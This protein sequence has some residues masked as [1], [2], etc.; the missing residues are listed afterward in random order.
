VSDARTNT[1]TP[2]PPADPKAVQTE[3]TAA[4][5]AKIDRDLAFL[6]HCF[7]EMLED[8]GEKE[9]ARHVAEGTW[10]GQ[11]VPPVEPTSRYPERIGQVYSIAFQLLN[12]VEENAAA[13][14]RR[15]RE[16]ALGL[17]GEPGLWGRYLRELKAAGMKGPDIAD[18]LPAIRVEPVLTAHPTEAKR[19]TVLEQHRAIYALMERMDANN[20]SPAGR[21]ALKDEVKAALERLWRTGEILVSKPEVADERENLMYYLVE[22]FPEV[23]RGVDAR[24]RQAWADA[25]LDP[26][27]VASHQ[28]M[29]KLRFGFW[30]GGD[31]DGHPMVTP[32]VTRQTLRALR[33]GAI[34]VLRRQLDRL[35][36]QL[37]LSVHGQR[38][39]PELTGL[40]E[41]LAEQHPSMARDVA[42]RET[43]EPWRQA[44][45]LMKHHLP[46]DADAGPDADGDGE[47]RYESPADLVDDLRTLR[48]TLER[49][50]AKRLALHDVDPVLRAVDTYGFHLAALDI[51]QNSRFHDRAMSQLLAAARVPDGASFAD[52]PEEKRL[53][54]LNAEL[55][56][57]RPFARLHNGIGH[58]AEDVLD[59]YR[60]VR[61]HIARHG[62]AGVGSLIVSMTH[63]L[64]DLLAVYVL[65]REAGLARFE[66][67]GLV[68]PIPVVPL[69][70]TIDDLQRSA[71]LLDG[72]LAHE[73]TRHSLIA[74]SK[75]GRRVQQ[76][77]LGYSDSTK[78]SGIFSSQWE[79]NRGTRAMLEVAGKHNVTLRFFHGRGGTISRGAGPTHRF[80]EAL[81]AGAHNGDVR[82]T[83]QGE[84]IAQKYANV[85][86][87]AYNTELLLAGVTSVALLAGKAAAP[88]A[89]L[90]A[91]GDR[92]AAESRKVYR[93]LLAADGFIP[94]FT[95]ATPVDALEHSSIGSRPSRRTGTRTLDDLRA[96]PWVFSWNQS[97]FYLPGWFGLGTAL[98]AVKTDDPAGF[99]KLS[100]SVKAWPLLRYVL[101]NVETNLSSADPE[102]MTEYAALVGDHAIR[103]RFLLNVLGEFE[104]TRQLVD[105]LL[106]GGAV[107]RRPRML[108]TL[109][110]RDARLRVLHRQQIDLLRRWRAARETDPTAAGKLLPQLLLNVNAI[111]SGLRTTG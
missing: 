62:R 44:A 95:Q 97:R 46:A 54:L 76:V 83:E 41:R 102:I 87:A 13:S 58:E 107:S 94:F 25:G 49:V 45:L 93:D 23:I 48:G 89:Q 73:V 100:E 29:P 26:S 10:T 36:E 11:A 31:R 35:A 57:P 92:I 101:V 99:A 34:T 106:G 16:A 42:R 15:A 14:T 30:V 111:A 6:T 50:G 9:L 110:L 19:A 81:P 105:E 24:L 28:D 4:G 85:S 77:M 59:C 75:R 68:C 91:L 60:V 74:Q 72:F 104:L 2:P 20:L 32:D 66:E 51:R 27:L 90:V 39:P 8:L 43:E 88:D 12:M 84:T 71:G 1:N 56:T 103:D 67:D 63:R 61:K 96:I 5:F 22:V 53:E 64:S 108:K 40:L 38:V 55:S 69:F 78:D 109:R 82:M 98:Q 7:R 17:A 65:A 33:R 37:S 47:A 70:E 80:L 21:A 3:L 18:A 79:L 52:W 86:T